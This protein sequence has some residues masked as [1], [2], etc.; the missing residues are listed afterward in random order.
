MARGIG[1]A[2]E[3]AIAS[4][5]GEAP[6][7]ARES[8]L[9]HPQRREMFRLLCLRPCATV[10]ELA[11][12]AGLSPNAARWH[13]DRM[14]A[15]GLVARDSKAGFYYPRNFIDPEDGGL[16]RAL[17]EGGTR[18]VFRTVLE[19][20]G[21]TQS[22]IAGALGV[23]RQ[24]V[25]KAAAELE[26]QRLLTHIADGRFRRYYPT[27]LLFERREANRTRARGFADALVKHLRAEALAPQV[28]RRTERQLLVRIT[29]GKASE[30]IDL[31]L[32]PYTTVLQ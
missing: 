9:M 19:M 7:E 4:E 2:F 23:S 14:S 28:L 12:H 1:R 32:D 27:G 21:S 24:S 16:F 30:T 29:R 10:G 26:A 31:T 11:R 13:L 8:L 3:K 20:Q 25:F 18:D 17:A 5:E 15:I 22:E 6:P